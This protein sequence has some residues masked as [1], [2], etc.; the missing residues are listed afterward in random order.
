MVYGQKQNGT[1]YFKDSLINIKDNHE[2]K[3]RTDKDTKKIV[4]YTSARIEKFQFEDY[5]M[6][7]YKNTDNPFQVSDRLIYKITDGEVSVYK[8]I[9]FVNSTNHTGISIQ[10]ETIV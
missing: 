9:V 3:F 5:G 7:Y 6:R 2:I 1:I 4:I 10:R 8:D